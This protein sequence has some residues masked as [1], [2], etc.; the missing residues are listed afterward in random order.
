MDLEN[1]EAFALTDEVDYQHTS[2]AWHPD[3]NQI[4]YVRYNQ[5]ALSEPPEVWLISADGEN[6]L[7]LIINGF[8]PGWIP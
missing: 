2:F 3:G 7:R 1:D 4:A 5:A 8:A 6:P